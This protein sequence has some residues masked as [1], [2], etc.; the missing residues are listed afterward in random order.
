MGKEKEEEAGKKERKK[1]RQ[2]ERKKERKR[3]RKELILCEN[4]EKAK[5]L[6]WAT[7]MRYAEDMPMHILMCY[8][9]YRS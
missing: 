5:H 6:I 7:C 2:T 9:Y 1:E 4:N 8:N 3:R